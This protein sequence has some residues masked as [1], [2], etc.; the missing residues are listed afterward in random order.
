MRAAGWAIFFA[1]WAVIIALNAF[2]FWKLLTEKP[3]DEI[4]HD[5]APPP[6]AV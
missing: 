4:T 1:S 3:A 5:D 2:C 6:P